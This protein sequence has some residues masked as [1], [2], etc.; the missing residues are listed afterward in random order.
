MKD[1]N[2]CHMPNERMRGVKHS[3]PASLRFLLTNPC[4]QRMP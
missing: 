1:K 4:A 2:I 3:P